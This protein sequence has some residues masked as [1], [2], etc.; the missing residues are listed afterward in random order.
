MQPFEVLLRPL[1]SEK[2]NQVREKLSKYVFEVNLRATKSDIAKAISRVYEVKVTSVRTNVTR[3][4]TRRRG[5]HVLQP[6]KFKKAIVTLAEGAKIP[7]FED[8]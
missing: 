7:L 3:D 2:S 8:Q 1:L 4:R 5:Q 6:R